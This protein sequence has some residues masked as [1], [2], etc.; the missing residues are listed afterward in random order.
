[1]SATK[2][3]CVKTASDKVIR[4]SLAYLSCKNGWRW[5]NGRP[6]L[7][8]IIAETDHILK[9]ADFQSISARSARSASAV[10][11]SEK[12]QYTNRKSTMGFPVSLR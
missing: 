11:P 3:P 4:H 6:V 8:K 9:S 2:F 12:L 1:M 7:P 10:T 5:T